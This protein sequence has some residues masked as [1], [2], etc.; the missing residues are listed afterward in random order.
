MSFV[1]KTR[2]HLRETTS[3]TELRKR[4]AFLHS[5]VNSRSDPVIRELIAD[6]EAQISAQEAIVHKL[7]LG[8]LG[9][10]AA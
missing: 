1:T 10:D 7:R 8:N 5:R 3:L 4:L 9:H 2:R 6:I